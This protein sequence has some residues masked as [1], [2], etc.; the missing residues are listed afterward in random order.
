M[1]AD[2]ETLRRLVDDLLTLARLDEGGVP[3]RREPVDL[4]DVVLREVQA[5][6]APVDVSAVS[7]A[8]VLG[9][10]AQLARVVRNLLENA[11]RHGG[12]TV[13]IELHED[14]E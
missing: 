10:S 11:V 6:G 5:V 13:S 1:L 7:G 14:G 2:T 9:D 4:D 12:S 8:Q 3:L